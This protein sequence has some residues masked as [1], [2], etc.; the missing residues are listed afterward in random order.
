MGV[1]PPVL[2]FLLGLITMDGLED[3]L[4]ELGM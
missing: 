1:V 4:F 2:A 3:G